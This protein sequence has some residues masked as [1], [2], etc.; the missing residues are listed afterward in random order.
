MTSLT[1]CAYCRRRLAVTRDHVVPRQLRRHY[2]PNRKV[3][4]RPRIPSEFMATVPC[5]LTCNVNK[6]TRHLVP[7]SWA[8][9]VAALNEFFCGAEFRVWD[10]SPASPAFTQ[11]FT[12]TP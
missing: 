4:Q 11:T 3:E 1:L 12:R 5:C 8:D 7:P 6:G 9:K 10:G 2:Q